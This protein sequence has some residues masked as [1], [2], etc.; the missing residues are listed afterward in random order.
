MRICSDS[1]LAKTTSKQ[2]R[3]KMFWPP[4]KFG[5]GIAVSTASGRAIPRQSNG[6]PPGLTDIL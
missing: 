2:Q 6:T 4:A 5:C 1:S 3:I